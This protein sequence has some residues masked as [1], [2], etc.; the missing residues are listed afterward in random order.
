MRGAL[1]ALRP[2]AAA[3][4]RGGAR[5]RRPR[6]RRASARARRRPRPRSSC[7]TVVRAGSAAVSLAIEKC[8]AASEA[9]CGRWVMQTTWR[10]SASS[11]SRSP[12]A[13]AVWPPMPASTSSKTSVAPPP[14]V[15]D[16]HQREHHARELAARRDVAQ[17]RR[18]ARPGWA[19]CGTRRRRR[20]SGPGSRSVST[21]SNVAP[22]MASP[23]SRSRTARGQLRRRRGAR[24]VQRRGGL[25]ALAP[26]R[27]RA[28]PSP[29]RRRPRRP[30][31]RRAARGSARRARAPPRSCRRACA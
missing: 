2:P 13:R 6:R 7:A 5:P 11:R 15:G 14:G 27:R 22:S 23:A 29:P 19:R 9:T 21:T 12:T 4:R 16:A 10:P 20:R 26:A 25:R 30:P 31:A 17:R 3:P 24:L 18:R 28:R 8:R 1:Q